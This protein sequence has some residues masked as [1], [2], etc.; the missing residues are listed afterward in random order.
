MNWF[1]ILKL[2]KYT[3]KDFSFLRQFVSS[4][5]RRQLGYDVANAVAQFL[6]FDIPISTKARIAARRMAAK[7]SLENSKLLNN[8][9]IAG[10]KI[11]EKPYKKLIPYG[12]NEVDVV[13]TFA[14]SLDS[15]NPN[16]VVVVFIVRLS[17][18]TVGNK[19]G[20]WDID[21]MLH[22]KNNL[23][24]TKVTLNKEFV[25][26]AYEGFDDLSLVFDLI[27]EV[28]NFYKSMDVYFRMKV[29]VEGNIVKPFEGIPIKDEYKDLI[30]DTVEGRR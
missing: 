28:S 22:V 7:E 4:R 20:E 11:I 1:D 27:E 29:R 5:L 8:I 17:S 30:R 24:R 21:F 6:F 14:T 16:A 3:L 23:F 19:S 25:V 15:S 18:Q 9:S 13:N 12:L 10:G 26:G 2:E